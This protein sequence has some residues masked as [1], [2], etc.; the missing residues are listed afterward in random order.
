MDLLQHYEKLYSTVLFF[1]VLHK[2]TRLIGLI[3]VAMLI[4]VEGPLE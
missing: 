2:K 1:H 4:W 3:W